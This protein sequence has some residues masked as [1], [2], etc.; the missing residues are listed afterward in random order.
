VRYAISPSP[1]CTPARAS[2]LTGLRPDTHGLFLND[3]AL[4]PDLPSLGKH[5]AASGYDTAWIGKW[6]VD[7]HGRYTYV[8][9]ERRQ[10]FAYFKG[11]ECSHKYNHSRYF[12]NDDSRMKIWDG[13][14][15]FPQTDD[16]IAWLRKRDASSPPFLA[17]LSWGPPH[18]PYE[19]APEPY[20]RHFDPS[21]LT[22]RGN[23]PKA[24][25]AQ[26]REDLAG[27]H[28]HCEALDVAMGRLLDALDELKLRDN[29]IVVFTSDHGDMIGSH[30][31]W[32]KQS[33]WDESLR[34]PMLI[35]AP[36]L[37]PAGATNDTVMELM[38]SWP[39]LASLCGLPSPPGNIH[40]RDLSQ[41]LA[42]NTMPADNAGYYANYTVFGTWARKSQ[43]D[44]LLHAREA[45]GVRT[46]KHLYVEDLS[47]PWLLYDMEA[48]PF[49]QRNLVDSPQ[50]AMVQSALRAKLLERRRACGD[51]FL[52]GEAY[53]RK[54]NYEVD[55]N[56]NAPIIG[57]DG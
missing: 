57:W 36:G 2:L 13:Y 18:A 35:R 8:P 38:D 41:H 27:Y 26:A 46:V 42:G 39:T 48:D 10:G 20:R 14:D 51:E 49:Q 5:F 50:H 17:M 23:V 40:A 3:V 52:S 7:G 30:G 37:L 55:S 29:T 12:D 47:G 4:G 9:R 44:P 19:T 31:L 33:P 43:T 11:L 22:L 25:E 15:A 16:L 34:I 28:A 6:H 56:G 45:R 54:W 53:L 32:E 1:V 24:S 21:R